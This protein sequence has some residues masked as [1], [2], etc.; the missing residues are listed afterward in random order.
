MNSWTRLVAGSLLVLAT[1][2][3]PVALAGSAAAQAPRDGS[4]AAPLD[5]TIGTNDTHWGSNPPTPQP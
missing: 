3:T 2:L 1:A 5:G 4:L